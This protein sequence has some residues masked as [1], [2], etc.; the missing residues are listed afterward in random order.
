MKHSTANTHFVGVPAQYAAF[1]RWSGWHRS[2]CY[3]DLAASWPKRLPMAQTEAAFAIRQLM[4]AV[5]QLSRRQ[6][7]AGMGMRELSRQS[8]ISLG[9][10]YSWVDSKQQLAEIA[11]LH[12]RRIICRG[13]LDHMHS[14]ASPAEAL[15]G[16]IRG[17]LFLTERYREWFYFA[18]MEARA[19]T[20]AS[21]ERIQDVQ[22][23][24]RRWLDATLARGVETH[25]WQLDPQGLSCEHIK[26]LLQH[27]Y[28]A[29]GQFRQSG[30]SV[31]AY[32]ASVE[33]AVAR[34]IQGEPA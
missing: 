23:E 16:F 12:T 10:L 17:H 14:E 11:V 26:A 28:V 24:S 25:G 29:R 18:Y 34:M 7:F 19:F 22:R 21:R 4:Q 3:Q 31:E 8:G 30:V 33:T 2:R 15:F 6:G 9:G 32:L 27:W 20:G 13:L 1:C 5:F